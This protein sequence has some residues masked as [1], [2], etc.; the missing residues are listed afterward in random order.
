MIKKIKHKS[1]ATRHDDIG[2]AR[3]DLISPHALERLAKVYGFGAKRHGERNWEKGLPKADTLNRVLRHLNEYR[4]GST[5]DDHL[6]HAFWGLAA[7]IHFEETG[8]YGKGG[9]SIE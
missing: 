3:F 8:Y 2:D 1:G 7:L 6:G 5:D 4:K 9:D